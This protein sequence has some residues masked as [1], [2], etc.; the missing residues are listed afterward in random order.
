M[1]EDD[2]GRTD[3]KF[4]NITGSLVSSSDDEIIG[5]SSTSTV[6]SITTGATIT[7]LYPSSTF[8]STST[9]ISNDKL[10]NEEAD[11]HKITMEEIVSE[12]TNPSSARKSRRMEIA[13]SFGNPKKSRYIHRKIREMRF[14][15]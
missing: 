12:S 13:L 8:S 7:E 10:N 15:R 4:V 11:S 6:T 1:D 5:T 9:A 2:N 3:E 14:V